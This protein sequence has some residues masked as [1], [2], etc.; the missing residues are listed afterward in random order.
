MM[1]SLTTA[2]NY[3]RQGQTTKM[4]ADSVPTFALRDDAPADTFEIRIH[5]RRNLTAVAGFTG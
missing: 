4:L 2:V 5:D 1:D 3:G